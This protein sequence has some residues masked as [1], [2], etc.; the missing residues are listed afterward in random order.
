MIFGSLIKM[1]TSILAHIVKLSLMTV[2]VL[3]VMSRFIVQVTAAVFHQIAWP[4]TEGNIGRY[5]IYNVSDT[6]K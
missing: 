6:G 4:K 5:E 1:R 3:N 2:I